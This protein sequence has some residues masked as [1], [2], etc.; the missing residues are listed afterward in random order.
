MYLYKNKKEHFL[1]YEDK[2][3]YFECQYGGNPYSRQCKRF[4]KNIYKFKQHIIN[5]PIGY[6]YKKKIYR[7]LA[8]W[9]DRE[10]N[11][12]SYYVIDY[13]NNKQKTVYTID[14]NNKQISDGDFIIVPHYGKMKVKI[15][16]DNNNNLGVIYNE[17]IY[18]P[19]EHPYLSRTPK[20]IDIPSYRTYWSVVGYVNK[21]DEF[22]KLYEKE[23]PKN[24]YQYQIELYPGLFLNVLKNNKKVVNDTLHMN[25]KVK[26][27]S[28][29]KQGY[30]SVHKYKY[31]D[32]NQ[33]N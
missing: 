25:D 10:S 4:F 12:Y 14:T 33:F 22:Y 13:N 16:N 20:P 29:E 32:L 7:P 9:Y 2:R 19:R 3:I 23:Y 26:I 11:K 27:E 17:S 30:Y 28:M 24:N 31:N 21:N 5:N 1:N 6:V 15:N 18:L 8:A